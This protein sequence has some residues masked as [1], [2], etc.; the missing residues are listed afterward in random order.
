MTSLIWT[1]LEK[2]QEHFNNA[3]CCTGSVVH[4]EK[5]RHFNRPGWYH[6]EW[7]STQYLRSNLSVIDA[8][9]QRKIW[10]MHCCIFPNFNN[11]APIFGFDIIAGKKKI[12]GCFYDFS[13]TVD[14]DHPLCKWWDQQTDNLIWKK[15]RN[16][17]PWAKEIFSRSMIA[18]GF[19]SEPTEIDQITHM[20]RLGIDT[21][22]DR[23]A[24]T[25][26]ECDSNW[27][28]QN[29]YCA[30]QKQNPHNKRVM[31]NLGLSES[32]AELF[33]DQCLF[34]EIA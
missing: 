25:D 12:T 23:V 2:V 30:N 6:A 11:P 15:E 18:A 9:E 13:P 24:H 1:E 3:L 10:M 33:V 14:V 34:P 31:I 21:Y 29:R 17:P 8:R 26:G 16:L 4:N 28:Q 20:A 19:V 32:D 5:I 7:N 27:Q 22:L